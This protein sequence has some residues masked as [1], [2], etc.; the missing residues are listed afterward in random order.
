MKNQILTSNVHP[1]PQI[2]DNNMHLVHYE[3]KKKKNNSDLR[4]CQVCINYYFFE[5][6]LHVSKVPL[7]IFVP[8]NYLKTLLDPFLHLLIP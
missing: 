6:K 2:V 1:F 3:T 8:S 4:R 5:V 7:S